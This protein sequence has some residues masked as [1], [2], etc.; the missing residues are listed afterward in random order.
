MSL[1]DL[2]N[3]GYWA[4]IEQGRSNETYWSKLALEEIPVEQPDFWTR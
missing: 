2:D 1:T 4:S 3:K